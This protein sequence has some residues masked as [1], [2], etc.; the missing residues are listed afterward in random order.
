MTKRARILL[1]GMVL[2]LMSSH[3]IAYTYSVSLPKKGSYSGWETNR[4][5]KL[6]VIRVDPDGPATDLRVGDEVIAINGVKIT[7]GSLSK[8]ASAPPGTR[9][10]LTIRRAGELRD[11]TYQTVPH[12]TRK[13]FDPHYFVGLLSLLTRWGVF[14]LRPEDKQ[15]WLL[16]LMLGTL[17]SV[18]GS[19]PTDLPSWLSLV[20]GS[21]RALGIL[22]LPIF[23]H[24]FLVFPETAPLLQRR[25]RLGIY[26]YLPCLIVILNAFGIGR[27]LAWFS[28]WLSVGINAGS[29]FII[30][31]YLAAGLICLAINY[32]AASP[33]A[34]RRLRVIMAGSA[35]GLFN[36]F[37]L[38]VGILFT[39]QKRMAWLESATFITLPLIPL[40]FVYA[41]V[42][43]KVIP[44]SLI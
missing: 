12:K 29:L 22:F 16:A 43:H 11:V 34:R 4:G 31:A 9:E 42:R 27:L 40:S 39:S 15:S 41:I 30:A 28:P 13:S 14:L 36:L 33:I 1:G 6:V 35:A 7:E 20:S 19:N 32:R 3:V 44:V 37:L 24:F 18:M 2:A 10:T 5:K 8:G 38:V 25:P 17:T 26:I 23:V 21:A